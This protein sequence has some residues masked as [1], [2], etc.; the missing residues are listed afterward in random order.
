MEAHSHTPSFTVSLR[1]YDR[2][3]VERYLD[4]LAEA[5]GQVEQ[6]E[7]EKRSLRGQIGRLEH[8]VVELEDR[9]QADTPKT[10]AV[11][12]ERIALLLRS[13]EETAGDTITRAEVKAEE[14]MADARQ[15][16][17]QADDQA[18]QT[19]AQSGEQARRIEASARAEASEIISD[20]ELRATARTRQIEQW[21]EQVVSHTR[22]EEARMLEE[23]RVKRD[24]ANA[25][26]RSLALQRDRV[27]QTLHDLRDALGQALGLVGPAQAILT[28]PS[29]AADAPPAQI[30]EETPAVIEAEVV[31]EPAQ[32]EEP[33]RA[34]EQMPWPMD[35]Q[36]EI[37]LSDPEASLPEPDGDQLVGASTQQHDID[38]FWAAE[39]AA[40]FRRS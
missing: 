13:A 16:I 25:E 35:E 21:A 36:Q 29:T 19:V 32:V 9:I 37:D 4:S 3:E 15:T 6:A 24:A 14:L 17:E 27:A 40:H 7:E 38:E 1:G 33:A 39:R 31:E 18:R 8:R 12:G 30:E 5:L 23:H 22:S 34:E 11:L 26:L 28:E 2:E 20:A 10:G